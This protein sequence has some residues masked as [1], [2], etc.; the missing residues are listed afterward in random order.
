VG[1]ITLQLVN[2]PGWLL[3]VFHSLFLIW[4]CCF[5]LDVLVSKQGEHTHSLGALI[6]SA[7]IDDVL[8][9]GF[10]DQTRVQK[11]QNRA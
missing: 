2:Q 9:A 11:H 6:S 7:L 4:L 10:A 1:A 5:W 8:R 3:F